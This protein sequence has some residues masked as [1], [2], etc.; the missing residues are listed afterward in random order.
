MSASAYGISRD[1]NLLRS[2]LSETHSIA[3][4]IGTIKDGA[5]LRSTIQTTIKEISTL[6]TSIKSQLTIL[7]QN[8]HD[9]AQEYELQFNEI[10]Q[11]M[12]T[13]LPL[14]ISKLK[15][16]TNGSNQMNSFSSEI[17]ENIIPLIDQEQVDGETEQI[18][19]LEEQVNTILTTMREVNDIFSS[20]LEKLQEQRNMILSI[21]NAVSDAND[22]ASKAVDQLNKAEKH[23]KFSR[24]CLCWLLLVFL[25]IAA[26]IGVFVWLYLSRN[27]GSKPSPAPAPTPTPTPEPTPAP[28]PG[29]TPDFTPQETE[30]K[31][32]WY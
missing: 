17:A 29:Q 21:D 4:D 14:I 30:N 28:T 16:N 7:N 31:Y 25:V 5:L 22:N 1:L 23:Q 2:K 9:Q 27:S 8:S 18:D 11:E 13:Q 24:K 15:E 6:S 10:Q 32:L 12:Q 19:I 20:T 26:G 3:Q